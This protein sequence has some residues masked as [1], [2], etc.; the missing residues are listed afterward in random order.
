MTVQ[1]CRFG[2]SQAFL[3]KI[4]SQLIVLRQPNV[5]QS[6]LFHS[7]GAFSVQCNCNMACGNTQFGSCNGSEGG[8]GEHFNAAIMIGRLMI[9]I[10]TVLMM[11]RRC[12]SST[13]SKA[14]LTT[15]A[16]GEFENAL[17]SYEGGLSLDDL[18]ENADEGL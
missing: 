6:D 14:E 3:E 2:G 15:A 7:F 17:I 16:E 12:L 4:V 18:S 13:E 11:R 5:V 10:I 9:V 1:L 8:A